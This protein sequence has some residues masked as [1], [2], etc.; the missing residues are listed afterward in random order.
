M[1]RG[2]STLHLFLIFIFRGTQ[3]DIIDKS[4]FLGSLVGTTQRLWHAWELLIDMIDRLIRGH[5]ISWEKRE[6]SAI[7]NGRARLFSLDHEKQACWLG[8]SLM[9]GHTTTQN[10]LEGFF[11]LA[12]SWVEESL[13]LLSSA[14]V[15]LSRWTDGRK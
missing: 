15:S 5:K 14:V 11:T 10:N 13:L 3:Q 7:T 8:A 6:T 4:G 12:S 9:F 2:G 1:G